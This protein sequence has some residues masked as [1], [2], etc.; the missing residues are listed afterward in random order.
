MRTLCNLVGRPTMRTQFEWN[1][2]YWS[3]QPNWYLI[4]IFSINLKNG[5]SWECLK[6]SPW[7][8]AWKVFRRKFGNLSFIKIRSCRP[9]WLTYQPKM[10]KWDNFSNFCLIKLKCG[11]QVQPMPLIVTE[12]F[13]NG[14]TIF[15]LTDLTDL[16]IAYKEILKLPWLEHF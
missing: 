10:K 16:K 2:S 15:S 11:V 5:I 12:T 1:C 4:E 13:G 6:L 9:A 7:F 8:F 14:L 3:G